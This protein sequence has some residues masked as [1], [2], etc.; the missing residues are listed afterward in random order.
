MSKSIRF[1]VVL[2]SATI[3]LVLLAVLLL[4]RQVEARLTRGYTGP[5]GG[6]GGPSE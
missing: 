4:N 6:P 1:F 5:G 2:L 3:G